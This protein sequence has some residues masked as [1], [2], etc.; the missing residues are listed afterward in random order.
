MNLA[1]LAAGALLGAVNLFTQWQVIRRLSPAGSPVPAVMLAF[2]SGAARLAL[3][4]VA[5][6]AAVRVNYLNGLLLLAGL[7][8]ARWAGLI[9][10]HIKGN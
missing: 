8:S 6:L 3:T 5:F 7:L 9:Y 2:F 1:W 10:M 4:A